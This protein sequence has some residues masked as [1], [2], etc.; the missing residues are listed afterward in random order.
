MPAK[1][2]EEVYLAERATLLEEVYV[3]VRLD[4][5][6]REARLFEKPPAEVGREPRGGVPLARILD[7]LAR[8]NLL[9]EVLPQQLRRGAAHCAAGCWPSLWPEVA[10]TNASP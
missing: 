9:V 5:P 6:E 10:V 1:F 4:L 2:L 8:V 7:L 3:L